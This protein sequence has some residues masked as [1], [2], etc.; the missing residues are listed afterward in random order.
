M[1]EP[2]ELLSLSSLGLLAS[3]RK[4]D[5]WREYF[6]R[7]THFNGASVCDTVD[8]F[9]VFF[10]LGYANVGLWY[11][12][13]ECGSSARDTADISGFGKTLCE[14]GCKAAEVIAL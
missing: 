13:I 2:V 6:M 8:A 1:Q 9:G 4:W 3:L 10:R 12:H 7:Q 14:R 11:I 5:F